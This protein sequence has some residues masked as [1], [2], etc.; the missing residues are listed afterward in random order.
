MGRKCRGHVKGLHAVCDCEVHAPE[1]LPAGTIPHKQRLG[2]LRCPARTNDG[3]VAL[4]RVWTA[5]APACRFLAALRRV[6]S[7][8]ASVQ[9]PGSP[10]GAYTCGVCGPWAH[11]RAGSWRPRRARTSSWAR[12]CTRR[13]ASRSCAA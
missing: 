11:E 10:V 2:A 9:V 6:D 13:G 12:P 8:R 5:G 1:S 7:R 3:L 4:R